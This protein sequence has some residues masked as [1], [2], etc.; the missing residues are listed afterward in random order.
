MTRCAGGPTFRLS[1]LWLTFGV[2]LCLPASAQFLHFDKLFG[3]PNEEVAFQIIPRADS[4]YLIVGSTGSYGP[5][6]SDQN[7]NGFVV[8]V[9][10]NGDPEWQFA[11]GAS[12]PDY[13]TSVSVTANGDYFL[14]GNRVNTGQQDVNLTLTRLT[15]SGTVLW[16]K[17][18]GTDDRSEYANRIIQFGDSAFII[19][20]SRLDQGGGIDGNVMALMV[21]DE[22]N[23]TWTAEYG[24]GQQIDPKDVT[25][26][27]DGALLVAGGMF[28]GSQSSSVL[29]KVIGDG[30]LIWGKVHQQIQNSCFNRSLVALTDGG[31]FTTGSGGGNSA[32]L[33]R[34]SP[35][36]NLLWRQGYAGAQYN[37]GSDLV[38]SSPTRVALT[39]N[40][41]YPS[42]QPA[43]S[44]VLL[45]DTS[46]HIVD[47]ASFGSTAS[48][49]FTITSSLL[50]DMDGGILLVGSSE[51]DPVP[52][53]LML[54]RMSISG[55]LFGEHCQGVDS[56]LQEVELPP[57]SLGPTITQLDDPVLTVTELN[58][59]PVAV[60]AYETVC[61]NVGLDTPIEIV[62]ARCFPNPVKD[63]LYIDV[64]SACKTPVVSVFDAT[65]RSMFVGR[66][67]PG[68]G[69][70][71]R[72]LA[73]G[74]YHSL[75]TCG[76]G[77]PYTLR[78]E[79]E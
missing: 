37:N 57:V 51:V 26:A 67:T 1:A 75:M 15:S 74:L 31:C 19:V 73:P 36:G 30:S 40:C 47:Q 54:K 52:R 7:S 65:G 38:L 3:G 72:D 78:F 29:M 55:D 39:V 28:A 20:G 53:E 43:I 18:I 5:G 46:G 11:L 10:N 8:K 17:E 71:V 35:G 76:S 41:S 34:Y 22:G 44:A 70:A 12:G 77:V 21:D 61:T 58:W 42:V 25:V 4:G 32:A 60:E 50:R 66:Y 45:T 49:S 33:S 14:V 24:C 64:P 2:S 59:T 6:A 9:D 16:I 48:S 68:S 23:I 56:L 79:V 62:Q 27:A 13:F 63:I 69:L